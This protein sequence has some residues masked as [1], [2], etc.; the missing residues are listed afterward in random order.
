MRG[1]WN[2]NNWSNQ[3][4]AITVYSC[5]FCSVL[6][7][8]P[9]EVTTAEC[10]FVCKKILQKKETQTAVKN[11]QRKACKPLHFYCLFFM[12]VNKGGKKLSKSVN[13]TLVFD[14]FSSFTYHTCTFS[15]MWYLM[16][17]TL[18]AATFSSATLRSKDPQFSPFPQSVQYDRRK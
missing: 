1:K 2:R 15:F 8:A 14:H 6:F 17:P 3:F 10:N 13:W 4:R 5:S 18:K 16:I 9:E 11:S 7:P 12:K